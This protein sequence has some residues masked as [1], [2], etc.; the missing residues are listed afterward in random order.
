M[1]ISGLGNSVVTAY[2]WQTGSQQWQATLGLPGAVPW[3]TQ[4][5]GNTV[6][7]GDSNLG[8]V[9]AVDLTTGAVTGHRTKLN[10]S[11]DAILNGVAYLT[12]DYLANA[13]DNHGTTTLYAINPDDLTDLGSVA[14][15]EADVEISV[16]SGHVV[17][18][19]QSDRIYVLQT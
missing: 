14:L 9:W 8:D 19:S 10:L 16:V 15:P 1:V 2:D 17:A 6:L 12:D 11:G 5:V 3:A 4:I 18:V 13:I 7:F